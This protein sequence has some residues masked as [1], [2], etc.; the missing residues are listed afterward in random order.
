[1]SRSGTTVTPSLRLSRLRDWIVGRGSDAAYITR[2][3]SI[4]YLAGVHAN[5][6]ERL[7]ALVVRPDHATLVVPALERDN[8]ARNSAQA[9]VVAWRDGEDPYKLVRAALAGST[10]LGIEK[11]H[12][13]VQAA[14]SLGIGAGAPEL[15]DIAPEIRRL[16]CTKSSDELEKIARACV[17]TDAVCEETM[18][19]L[20]A[21]QSELAVAVGIGAAIAAY[22]A[23]PAFEAI[24][25]SGPNSAEPHHSASGRQLK[26]GDLVLLDFGAAFEGY[27]ADTTRMAVVGEPSARQVEIHDLVL[28]AHDAAIKAVRA[29]VTTGDVDAAAREVIVAAGL[30]D[31][32]FHRVGH[33]LGLEAHEDPSLDPGSNT[34]LEPGMVFTIEP[35]IYIP[36]W[37]GVR[38]EDDVVVE[39]AGCRVLTS[40][41]RNLRIVPAG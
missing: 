7:M 35:G 4:A 33:G 22:G 1:L 25:Q 15:L 10:R 38:I 8:A 19:R 13:T 6:H 3:V 20:R 24:V 30:G 14:E 39:E 37:G 23:S 16:R 36:L 11:E 41:D 34:M 28:E 17:I 40:A 31:R 2:P 18:Q 32:F 26:A 21:G 5:P 27:R 12:L 9:E 29:G